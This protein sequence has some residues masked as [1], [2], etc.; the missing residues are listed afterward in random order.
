MHKERLGVREIPNRISDRQRDPDVSAG[1]SLPPRADSGRSWVIILTLSCVLGLAYAFA[2]IGPRV[3]NPVDV[4]WMTGDPAT[5]YLGWAFFRREEHLTLPLGWSD[6]IGYPLGE[7]I[8]YFDS[9]PLLAVLGWTVRGVLPE[10]FQYFGIYFVLC[11]ILQFYFGL[12]ISRRLCPD[13][14]GAAVLGATLFLMAPAFTWR[15]SGH[16]ALASHWIVVA[17]LDQLL[18]A[19]GRPSRTQIV[20]RGG[21]CFIAGSINPYITAMALLVLSGAYFR[22]LLCRQDRVARLAMGLGLAVCLALASLVLFGFVRAA[23]ASQYAGG[24]YG[25]YSMNLLAPV[26][27]EK[28]G[29][30]LLRQQS[31]GN[32]QYEGYNY[33]GLGLLLT[34]IVAIARKPDNLRLLLR[35]EAIP[36]LAIFVISL[37]LALSSFARLGPYT[38]WHFTLPAP[39]MVVLTSFRASGRLFW[40]GYYLLIIGIIAL[41]FQTIPRRSLGVA[42][43]IVAFVQFLDEL[44]LLADIRTQ[45][46]SATASS[47][48]SDPAWHDL[49]QTQRHLVVIPPWQCTMKSDG[50]AT[51]GRLALEQHLTVNSFYAGRYNGAQMAFFCGEQMSQIQRDGFQS[52]TAYVFNRDMPATVVGLKYN[53]KYCRAVD[54]YILCSQAA[55]RS[56]LDSTVLANLTMLHTGDI[57]PFFGPGQVAD[58]LTGLGWSGAEQWGRWSRGHEATLAFKVPV[59]TRRDL[60]IELSLLPFAPPPRPRQLVSVSVNGEVLAQQ[61]F[62]QSTDASMTVTVPTRLMG[63]DGVVRLVFDLPDAISP[64]SVGMS[65]DQRVVAIGLEQLRVVDGGE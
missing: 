57:V 37:L 7:P 12:R 31:I 18:G 33:L 36:A 43:G 58:T 28:Y 22:P 55:P 54:Q 65:A 41:A 38:L 20:A 46:T 23:D 39:I 30:L 15:A 13:N 19:G 34:G 26:D 51:F 5:G 21:L 45:W 9:I 27:P 17:A 32:G 8:A 40:P 61:T 4:S 47:V 63:N 16:F 60:R 25:V 49:G 56:G 59:P 50:Y 42:L 35:I 62:T 52:D 11:C 10:H 6:A 3:L 64:A 2:V 53:G 48:S 14:F 1:P 24:G 44:P 29:A